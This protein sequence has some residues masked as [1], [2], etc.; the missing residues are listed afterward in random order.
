MTRGE[1]SPAD[2]QLI[3]HLTALG[4]DV[5]AAQL[6]RWRG[7]GLLPG[8]ARAWLGRGRGSV[9][10][11]AEETVAVA[12]AIAE[13]ARPGRDLR[14]T[15]IAWYAEAGRPVVPGE[16]VVPEPPWPAVHEA[17]L[18][19]AGRSQAQRLAAAGRAAAAAGD[20]EQ[21]AFYTH[22]TR[23]FGRAPGPLPHPDELL[24]VVQDPDAELERGPDRRLRRG[25]VRLIAAAGM[26]ADEV[27]GEAFVDALAALMPGLDW[28]PVAAEARRAEEAGTLEDWVRAGTLDPLALL[29]A[30]GEQ[31][32]A[33]ARR[34]AQLLA[35][36]G[37]LYVMHGLLM[38]DTPGLAHLREQLDASGFGVIVAQLVPLMINPTGVPQALVMCLM[39]V[40]GALAAH[41]EAL[42]AQQAD[43]GRGLLWL[44]GDE[45][46][47]AEAYMEAWTGRVHQLAER[48]RTRRTAQQADRVDEVNDDVAVEACDR[49]HGAGRMMEP[50]LQPDEEGTR[51]R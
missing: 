2:Q 36:I 15:V 44:P 11:L 48:S 45:H 38:P 3:E 20:A 49:P 12:A 10:V 40:M 5:S 9:S 25:A 42:L 24:R 51:S 13:H 4:L 19:A 17:L 46:G 16:S 28:A 27:G 23:L 22:V 47:S 41:F 6:E 7:A 43:T 8:H 39:P 30:A 18:W 21:D 29:R 32:V 33:A 31:E 35:G 50:A 37:G 26:G 14:W 34:T 1:P